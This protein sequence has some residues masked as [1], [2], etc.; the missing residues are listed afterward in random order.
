MADLNF[1]V[2]F[3]EDLTELVDETMVEFNNQPGYEAQPYLDGTLLDVV[4][5]LAQNVYDHQEFLKTLFGAASTTLTIL[6]GRLSERRDKAKNGVKITMEVDGCPITIE[7]YD[8]ES[9]AKLLEQF[10]AHYPEQ[11]KKISTKSKLKIKAGR[12]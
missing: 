8:T 7:S 5:H 3:D 11:A 12:K 9:A 2:E 1:Q 10:Q 6:S 4:H